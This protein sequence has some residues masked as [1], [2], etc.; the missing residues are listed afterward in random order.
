MDSAKKTV[1]PE[2][3]L[4]IFKRTLPFQVVSDAMLRKVAAL[5]LRAASCILATS[6]A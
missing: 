6:R 3:A 2:I 4:D 5:S 1:M